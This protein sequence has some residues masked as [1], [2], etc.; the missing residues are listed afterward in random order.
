MTDDPVLHNH[1]PPDAKV[2]LF[3]SLFRGR[4]DVYP[5]RFESRKSGKNG[6]QPCCANEWTKGL[7]DKRRVKCIKCPNRRF[8]PV[9]DDVIRHHLSGQDDTGRTFVM[10]VYPMLMD[11]TCFLLAVDFDKKKASRRTRQPL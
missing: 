5:L 8:L 2:A 6:Y 1:S 4:E 9:T 11:E 10:G 7:C 3:R